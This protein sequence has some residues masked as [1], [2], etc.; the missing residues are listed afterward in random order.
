MRK[1]DQVG[2]F[3]RPIKLKTARSEFAN[4]KITS[5]QLRKVEDECIKELLIECDK[6]G[7][8]Y[9]TDGEFRR[10]WWHLDFYWGFSG[11]EKVIREKGYIFKGIETRAEGVKIVGKIECKNHP[12]IKDY[13]RLV[14]LAKELNIDTNRLK[15]TI[16]SP[17]MF[18]YM[19]FIR[20][21][22]NVEFEYYGKDYAKLKVD[23]LKAYEDFYAE[24]SKVG[25]VYLQLD[26][27]SFG[28][29]CDVDFRAN[30][31]ANKVDAISCVNEYV[32]FLN[33]SL[34]TMPKN[35]TTGIHI[36]RGNYRSHFSA[37]GGYE[38]VA[39]KLFGELKI[40]KFFLEFDSDRA[41][42]F[43]P[44]RFIK[45]QTVVLGLLTTKVKENPSL[46]ELKIRAKEAAK[47]IN[48]KQIE[49]STQCGFSSTEEGNEI[50]FDT[51][52]EKINLLNNLNS[53]LE[54]E[55]FFA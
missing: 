12:F 54:K 29:F 24:F 42:D 46:D 41:G 43:N 40:N 5:E 36:C 44:L 4:G 6:N 27:V 25:G 19:L 13:A 15:L 48:S 52:W 10:S 38:Y 39:Q 20:G 32:D 23:I 21:G 11:V 33:K 51:Q 9:L 53:S 34:D 16:P 45:N 28:S 18:I 22:F 49:F 3:L 17:A 35:I 30:L 8:Y 1:L 50:T 37:S 31:S 2:S 55:G 7:L 26:D 14:E 47:V